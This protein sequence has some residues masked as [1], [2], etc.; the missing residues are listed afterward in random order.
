MWPLRAIINTVSRIL[1]IT[2][3][4][5]LGDNVQ[6]IR[7][8]DQNEPELPVWSS[9]YMAGWGLVD[10]SNPSEIL[11]KLRLTVVSEKEC[12]K[13][14][15]DNLNDKTLCARGSR[16][17]GTCAGDSGGPLITKSN[18]TFTLVGRYEQFGSLST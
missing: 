9:V 1:Q 3:P 15:G 13:T 5:E 16:P 18:G 10:K 14:W 7:L 17:N 8:P 2:P 11:K 4:V 6:P 12:E